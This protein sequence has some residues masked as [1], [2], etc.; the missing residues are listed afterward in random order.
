MPLTY[1]IANGIALG[2]VSYTVVK[3]LAGK[4]REVH[5]VLYGLT[6]LLAAYYGF[7]GG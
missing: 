3:L 5:P 6:V 4:P 2:L 7:V 1:S